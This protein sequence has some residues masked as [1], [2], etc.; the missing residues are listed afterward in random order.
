MVANADCYFEVA[1]SVFEFG[2]LLKLG[3]FFVVREKAEVGAK[4]EYPS[5]CF[6]FLLVADD[7]LDV[8]HLVT[9]VGLC[10]LRGGLL[11]SPLYLQYTHCSARRQA[12]VLTYAV[13]RIL[14][15]MDFGGVAIE[16]RRCGEADSK[17]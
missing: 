10:P 14:V 4:C 2:L 3:G 7:V 17:Y 8:G 15:G 12:R 11:A 13:A 1:D 5:G 16:E 9:P 6:E